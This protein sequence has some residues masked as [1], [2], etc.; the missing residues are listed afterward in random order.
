MEKKRKRKKYYVKNL[1]LKPVTADLFNKIKDQYI[2]N[3]R[4]KH[5]TNTFTISDTDFAQLLFKFVSDVNLIN[6]MDAEGMISNINSKISEILSD[7][8]D[9]RIGDRLAE[10]KSVL[11]ELSSQLT[12]LNGV[13]TSLSR[14]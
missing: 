1:M 11:D 6:Q 13:L 12:E 3:I 10:I 4:K 8:I 14:Y 5:N 9:E 2:E 7:V